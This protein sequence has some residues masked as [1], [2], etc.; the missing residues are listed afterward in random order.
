[1]SLVYD[2]RDKFKGRPGLHA[3][4]IGVSEYPY[5]QGGAKENKDPDRTLRQGQLTSAATSAHRLYQWLV[6]QQDK[7]RLA[8]LAS[9]RLLL[10]PSQPEAAKGLAP[11]DRAT[12]QNALVAVGEWREDA[13]SHKDN[14]ALFYFAGHGLEPKAKERALLLEDF[15]DGVGAILRNS[16]NF[17][18]LHVGM[19]RFKRR[20]GVAGTQ[21]YFVDACRVTPAA[22]KTY[23]LKD[24]TPAFEEMVRDPT[25]RDDRL[26]SLFYATREGDKAYGYHG[27][28][29]LFNRALIDCLD[30]WAGVC[31]EVDGEMQ[32]CVTLNSLSTAVRTLVGRLGKDHQVKQ[33]VV[34]E[35]IDAELVIR[36][37]DC[38]P[39]V[40][41]SLQVAPDEAV[42]DTTIEI[43]DITKQP[44]LV[45]NEHQQLVQV[46][47]PLNPHPF[48]CTLSA[49]YYFFNARVPANHPTYRSR[50]G[51][52]R[53]VYPFKVPSK[54][55]VS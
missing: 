30:G 53:L 45:T 32:W 8:D 13:S 35:N 42:R 44:V 21:L 3:F 39:P 11:C 18:S 52:L 20:R 51:D 43:M 49:G 37:L 47:A 26:A 40:A 22:A 36:N 31:E 25:D 41:L 54:F 6:G 4:I 33:E 10:S 9:V 17:E 24:A 19:A 46:P 1:M 29:T 16:L 50:I 5:L 12:M 2:C 48:K 23:H 38:P 27:G 7:M 34:T 55:V 28:E 14:V 15:G